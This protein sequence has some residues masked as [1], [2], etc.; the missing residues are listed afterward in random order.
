MELGGGM[1][2]GAEMEVQEGPPEEPSVTLVR[3]GGGGR[4]EGGGARS[5]LVGE[6][7]GDQ[8]LGGGYE[9]N[10]GGLGDRKA[11]V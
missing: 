2:L 7:G 3:E 10:G 1:E 4:G 8:G 11:H 6:G 5:A 9:M